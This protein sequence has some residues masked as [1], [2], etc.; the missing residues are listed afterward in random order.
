MNKQLMTLFTRSPLH[1]GKR[2]ALVSDEL[3]AYFAENACEVAQPIKIVNQ[4]GGILENAGLCLH[5]RFFWLEERSL[6]RYT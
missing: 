6:L 4:A 3:F 2:L 1:V 5:L